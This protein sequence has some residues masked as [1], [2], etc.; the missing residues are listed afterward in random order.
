M[1]GFGTGGM[2]ES[3]A[4]SKVGGFGGE[5]MIP[6]CQ[7]LS[8]EQKTPPLQAISIQTVM[9]TW[10]RG[11]RTNFFFVSG[12]IVHTEEHCKDT[13][14]SAI[15]DSVVRQKSQYDVGEC[16]KNSQLRRMVVDAAD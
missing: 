11:S 9:S 7:W 1:R 4:L 8:N 15:D 16:E 6:G 5:A 2:G 14:V 10:V 3:A 12:T 13:S